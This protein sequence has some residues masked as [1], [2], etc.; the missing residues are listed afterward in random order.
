MARFLRFYGFQRIAAS[1]L[2][3]TL[4]SLAVKI[5]GGTAP[6]YWNQWP[7]RASLSLSN[8]VSGSLAVAFCCWAFLILRP[9]LTMQNWA[10]NVSRF[11]VGITLFSG[12]GGL[13]QCTVG[14]FFLFTGEE[15]CLTPVL[16]EWMRAVGWPL[17]IGS[18]PV[19]LLE[20]YE[21]LK[22][23]PHLRRWLF[24]GKGH[25]ATWIRSR[26]LK[27]ISQP[28]SDCRDKNAGYMEK[29]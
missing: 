13:W 11:A 22:I 10:G 1:L 12:V 16:G 25:A 3:A 2:G 29:Y 26:E 6:E 27:R 21:W 15:G 5:Q 7:P 23:S 19:L 14:G 28:L 4:M 17:V 18:I 8:L 24:S 20:L 9:L